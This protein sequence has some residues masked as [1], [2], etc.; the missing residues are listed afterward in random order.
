MFNNSISFLPLTNYS[1][2]NANGR[3]EIP[4]FLEGKV[5][6]GVMYWCKG[7]WSRL[8]DSYGLS[9]IQPLLSYHLS[10]DRIFTTVFL[11]M[12]QDISTSKRW[13][14]RAV[15]LLL[16]FHNIYYYIYRLSVLSFSHNNARFPKP[17]KKQCFKTQLQSLNLFCRCHI[18]TDSK[19]SVEP[20]FEITFPILLH[21]P[22]WQSCFRTFQNT[23]RYSKL[24]KMIRNPFLSIA[25]HIVSKYCTP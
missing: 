11:W 13:D 19:I 25:A 23:Y 17:E 3:K 16:S 14:S 7:Q 8:L 22:I 2:D 18:L 10:T 24:F 9:N 21:K 20:G 4:P 12:F 15:Q 6:V 5:E 1:V